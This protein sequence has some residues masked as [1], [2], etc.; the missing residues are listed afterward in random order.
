[1]NAEREKCKTSLSQAIP[2]PN[3][4]LYIICWLTINRLPLQFQSSYFL[5]IKAGLFFFSLLCKAI[6]CKP[7]HV[8]VKKKPKNL[9]TLEAQ[10]YIW[11]LESC[12]GRRGYFGVIPGNP[13]QILV[14]IC[15]S[16]SC[17]FPSEMIRSSFNVHTQIRC[18]LLMQRLFFFHQCKQSWS[19]Y[20][21]CILLLNMNEVK[22][23]FRFWPNI[24]LQRVVKCL[25]LQTVKTA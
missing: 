18:L 21:L 23:T 14:I 25:V 9:Q 3:S 2:V 12:M 1:M 20:I 6:A 17:L 8:N 15:L 10:Q 24:N 4:S 7:S 11:L 22:Q 13:T 19:L 16:Q 5:W